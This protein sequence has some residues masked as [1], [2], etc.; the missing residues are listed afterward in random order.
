MIRAR[1]AEAGS[2]ARSRRRSWCRAGAGPA[3][4]A[5]I[6]SP[7]IAMAATHDTD[8]RT[9][10]LLAVCQALLLTNGSS[11]IAMQAL[12]G[13]QLASTKSLATLGATTYVL[14]S[15]IATMPASLWMARVGRRAGFMAGAL[16]NVAGCAVAV[17]ALYVSSF[18]LFCVATAI[19]GVYNAI[20]LQYRFAAAEIAAPADRAK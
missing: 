16:V 5:R 10:V 19:I 8:R 18:A 13:Y 2:Q 1:A 4:A 12:V 14:G 3:S 15:A 11:L 17:L 9:L 6:R 20:G 7:R